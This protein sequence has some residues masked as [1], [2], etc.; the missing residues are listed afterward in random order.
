LIVLWFAVVAYVVLSPVACLLIG[1]AIR[2][3]EAERPVEVAPPVPEPV[4]A[5]TVEPAHVDLRSIRAFTGRTPRALRPR[6]Q[7][8]ALRTLGL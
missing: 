7:Q 2:V 8:G 4:A 1:R 5:V 6:W 3:R